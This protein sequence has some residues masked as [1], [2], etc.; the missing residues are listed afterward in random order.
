MD[1]VQIILAVLAVAGIIYIFLKS[2][3]T[4]DLLLLK[5]F[6][7]YVLGSFRFNFN[8]IAIPI[9][10]LVYLALLRPKLNAKNKRQAAV[11]GLILFAIGLA[12]PAIDNYLYQRPLEVQA[13][14]TNV[15]E[16][17]FQND[18]V[19]LQQQLKLPDE[20]QLEDFEVDFENDGSIRELRY[21]LITTQDGGAVYYHVNLDKEQKVY[22]IRRYKVNRWVDQEHLVKA[23]RFFE[24]LS[25]LNIEELKPKQEYSWHAVSSEGGLRTYGIKDREKYLI[26]S[27]GD[28]QPIPNERLPV[29]LYCI[30]VYG[31]Q[32]MGEESYQSQGTKEYYFS[33]Y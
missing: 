23:Q 15:Y 11:L 22:V 28:I 6:G 14:S 26:G 25:S 3:R 18:W 8:T 7:Y 9:G 1:L 32:Q 17:D 10:F 33:V 21:R 16:F 5:L 2:D 31:M 29:E 27:N 19:L 13:K 20:V 12:V 24:V 30:S 4:E